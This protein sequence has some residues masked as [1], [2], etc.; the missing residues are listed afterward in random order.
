MGVALANLQN[1]LH[2]L[3]CLIADLT[4]RRVTRGEFNA[5]S[6]TYHDLET[7]YRIRD[8]ILARIERAEAGGMRT[9]TIVPRDC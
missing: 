7:L 4:A 5:R 8:G 9:R 3:N 1:E 2:N 6:F